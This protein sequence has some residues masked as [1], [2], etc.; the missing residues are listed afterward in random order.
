M[1]LCNQET[2]AC[3]QSCCIWVRS[4]LI[5]ITN[6]VLQLA[7]D[8]SRLNIVVSCMNH[9][10]III[11]GR[12]IHPILQQYSGSVRSYLASHGWRLANKGRALQ[13]GARGGVVCIWCDRRLTRP[14][15]HQRNAGFNARLD[16]PRG[17][18]VCHG[19]RV[20]CVLAQLWMPFTL[21]VCLVCAGFVARWF[22]GWTS[23]AGFC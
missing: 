3:M 9:G 16:E 22:E 11:A 5:F 17:F 1:D 7:T 20:L 10:K 12:I 6:Q 15:D 21:Y 14:G 18:E 13:S 2:F 8:S 4:F 23:G 19:Q